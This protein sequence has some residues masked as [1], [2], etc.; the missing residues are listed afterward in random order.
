ML[1]SKLSI[2][3]VGAACAVIVRQTSEEV[4]AIGE[5]D[6]YASR[7]WSLEE[8]SLFFYLL[9]C[10]FYGRK[11][12]NLRGRSGGRH[13][14]GSM[15]GRLSISLAIDGRREGRLRY[16]FFLYTPVSV[17]SYVS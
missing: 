14:G 5:N 3:G 9:A 10:L 12:G 6:S 8:F 17:V 2:Y 13:G 7:L 11:R 15:R 4:L 1:S 16:L